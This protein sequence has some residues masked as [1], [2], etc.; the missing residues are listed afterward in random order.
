MNV[1]TKV[2]SGTPEEESGPATRAKRSSFLVTLK[3]LG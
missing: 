1:E 3:E 2:P